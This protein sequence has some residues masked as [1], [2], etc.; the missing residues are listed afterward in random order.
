[1]KLILLLEDNPDRLGAFRRAIRS[2]GEDWSVKDWRDAHRMISEC[3]EFLGQAALISLDHDLVSETGLSSDPGTGLDAASHFAGMLPACPVV[4]HSSNSDAAWS[5]HNELRF[6]GWHVERVG[7][8]GEDWIQHAWLT[9]A[10]ELITLNHTSHA[11]DRPPDHQERMKR[12]LLSLEGLAIGDALG[13]MLA[14]RFDRAADVIA[15]DRLPAGPWLQT[16]DNEMA[17]SIVDVL[18]FHGRI[19]QDALARRFAWR[20]QQDPYRGYGRMTRL[21][22][23]EI[24]AGASW[25]QSSTAA[26]GGQGSMGN[27]GGIG[28]LRGDA[29]SSRRHRRHSRRGDR[30]GHGVA[31]A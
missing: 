5:M 29:H 9:K 11:P 17:L 7:P 30:G 12:V 1:M 14:S 26:F 4:I 24:Q 28:V 13:E 27:G 22:M 25:R 8:L 2:L 6:A 20:F 15:T 16:D 31:I 3:E 21:Q 10:R 23:R 19:H 18:R